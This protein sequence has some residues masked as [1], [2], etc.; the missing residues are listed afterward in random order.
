M[1]NPL[2]TSLGNIIA[3]DVVAAI[4]ATPPAVQL[5]MKGFLFLLC[6][7]DIGII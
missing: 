7:H 4:S 5:Y 1:V 6:M 3:A 2:S